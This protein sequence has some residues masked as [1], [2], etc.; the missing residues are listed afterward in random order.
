MRKFLAALALVA[1]LAVPATAQTVVLK[2]GDASTATTASVTAGYFP[3]LIK[4]VGSSPQGGTVTVAAGGDITLKTGTVASSTADLTTECPVSGAYG[5]IID[6]SD[7]ACNTLGE[8]VDAINASANWRAVIQDGLR[9]D[10][11]D[12][13]LFTLTETSASVPQGLALAGDSAV[14]L[15]VTFALPQ[16]PR[17]DIRPYMIPGTTPQFIANPFADTKAGLVYAE[18][19]LVGTGAD[20]IQFL[21]SVPNQQRCVINTAI[22]CSASETVDSFI[23][24]GG[25][26]TV[27]SVLDFG[28]FA[29]FGRP[30]QRLLFRGA[31]ATTLTAVTRATA[32]AATFPR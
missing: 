26:T 8:V 13:T 1:A 30:G 22:V 23:S 20:T 2:P 27:K 16:F 4:Y 5:G 11:S 15:N 29:M 32:G 6:V 18:S 28:R 31:F 25:G 12:N 19:T 10:S 21:F 17:N 24:T 3:I 7:T 9:A 14:S